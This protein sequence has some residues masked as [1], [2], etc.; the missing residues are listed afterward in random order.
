MS[1][2]NAT[3]KNVFYL[4]SLGC[5]LTEDDVE[6]KHCRAARST[7]LLANVDFIVIYD[8][9]TVSN[10]VVSFDI[11]A[12]D[13]WIVMFSNV[14]RFIFRLH[15]VNCQVFYYIHIVNKLLISPLS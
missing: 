2:R 10:H 14:F 3:F 8:S 6:V 7:C 13:S 9:V 1:E 4:L 5:K 15:A 12:C 11:S